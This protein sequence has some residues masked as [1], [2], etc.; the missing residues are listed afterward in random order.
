MTII[1]ILLNTNNSDF[2]N[3]NITINDKPVQF[4]RLPDRLRIDS[5]IEY[6]IHMLKLQMIEPSKFIEIREVLINKSSLRMTLHMSFMLDENNKRHQPVCALW[7]TRQTWCLP[8]GNPVSFWLDLLL[9]KFPHGTF[10]QDLDQLYDIYWPEKINLPESFP[11]IVRDFFVNDFDFFCR[12]KNDPTVPLPY[13]PVKL[14]IDP[15]LISSVTTEILKNSEWVFNNRN[16]NNQNIYKTEYN[17]HDDQ[18]WQVTTIKQNNKWLISEQQFPDCIRLIDSLGVNEA[19]PVNIGILP[20][21]S[22]IIPHRDDCH[23]VNGFNNQ[24]VVYIPLQWPEGNYFKFSGFPIFKEAYPILHTNTKYPHCLVNN[25]DQVRIV[26]L[27]TVD[28]EKNKFLLS[29]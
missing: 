7:D 23:Q 26:I 25:S 27:I 11:D 28:M 3:L 22:F 2:E 24:H 1:D 10:G 19:Y 6:G 9:K 20:P 21:M 12:E 17:Q 16:P 29:L 4:E 5:E 15:D 18:S 14:S 8:F 13:R